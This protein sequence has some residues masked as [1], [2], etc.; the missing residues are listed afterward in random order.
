MLNHE[1]AAKAVQMYGNRAEK[2][3]WAKIEKARDT[4][5]RMIEMRKSARKKHQG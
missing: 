1:E 2:R 5:K 3:R 4:K